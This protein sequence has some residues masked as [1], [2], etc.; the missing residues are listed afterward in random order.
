MPSK[1]S[2]SLAVL[3]LALLLVNWSGP[4]LAA[5]VNLEKWRLIRIVDPAARRAAIAA[6]EAA[7]TQLEEGDCRKV[8]TD[9]RNGNGATLADQLSSLGVDIQAYFAMITFIDT[10]H[11]L[12]E[13]GA[14]L[15]TTPGSRV[16]RVCIDELKRLKGNEPNRRRL[17]HPRNTAHAGAARGPAIVPGDHGTGARTVRPQV[18]GGSRYAVWNA[19]ARN[20]NS[21]MLPSCGCSQLS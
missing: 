17:V 5:Q 21:T 20:R 2:K 1:L 9:F 16:V 10:R 4:T 12:C 6:L 11:R 3:P 8:L 14:V 13:G 18:G 7:A 19:L 15:F